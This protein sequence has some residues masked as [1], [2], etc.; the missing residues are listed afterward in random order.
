MSNTL[1]MC[2]LSELS[3]NDA[4]DLPIEQIFAL[5]NEIEAA[6]TEAKNARTWLDNYLDVRYGKV[7]SDTR[8]K[9]G[10][11]SGIQRVNDDDYVVIANQKQTI[12]WDQARL[13]EA[14]ETVASWGSDVNEYVT[15]ELSVS[16]SKFKAWEKR[17]KAVFEPARTIVPGKQSFVIDLGKSA[18]KA[19]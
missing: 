6:A 18:A 14:A 9:A 3:V 17:I 13:R 16:E 5:Q 1:K 2:Q 4:L 12:K 11:T 8:A 10:K 15:T 7:A 19:A